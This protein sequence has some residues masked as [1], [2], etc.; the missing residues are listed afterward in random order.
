[1]PQ[2]VFAS[3]LADFAD[4]FAGFVIDQWGVL[5]DG[6]RPYP[7]VP[8]ALAELKR[9]RKR[10]VLLSN[11]GRRA[12]FNR[13]KLAEMG[14]DLADFDAVVTSGEAAWLELKH[15]TRPPFDSLGRRCLLLTREGD[16]TVVDG[17]D[18]VLVDDAATADFIFLSGVENAA[19]TLDD[20][21]PLLRAARAGSLPIVCSNPDLVAVSPG[22][23]LHLAPGT[24]TE[25]YEREGGQVVYVGKPHL[26]IY[27]AC[28][29]ALDGLERGEIVAIGDS[30]QHDIKGAN[31]AGI[32]AAFIRDGIHAADFPEGLEAGWPAALERL[33][34]R[35]DARADYVLPRLVW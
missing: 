11:S 19:S 21:L 7:W 35:H 10:I 32:A 18:L 22:G 20:Y 12:A 30:L 23:G 26:P 5:H 33:C 34:R 2:P 28:L 14:F 4:R 15:K 17:L 8:A 31:N 24:L 27:G 16:R 1:M 13:E 6:H 9:R 3:G 29:D 25:H